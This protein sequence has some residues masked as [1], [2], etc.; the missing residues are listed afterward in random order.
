MTSIPVSRELQ[1]WFA[2]EG[3]RGPQLTQDSSISTA[4]G[5]G[6]AEQEN[7]SAG[8]ENSRACPPGGRFSFDKDGQEPL[9]G[10]YEATP[11][12][13][14]AQ[15]AIIER[16]QI[17]RRSYDMEAPT[18]R[19]DRNLATRILV[20]AAA[21]EKE[22]YKH[23]ARYQHRG[24]LG[25]L[26]IALLVALMNF[27]RKYGRIFPDYDTL[28]AMLRK[29]PET[30]VAAMKRLILHGFVTKH[31][32]S[33][34]I[35]TPQGDRR[36]Q[37]SNAYE[38]HM[39]NAGLSTV[40]IVADKASGSENPGVSDL[41]DSRKQRASLPDPEKDRWWLAEPWRMADGIVY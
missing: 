9:P 18:C 8:L 30:I 7:A 29:N 15:F 41:Q 4:G 17:H 1:A 16:G 31:R 25:D 20:K 12:E 6:L 35:G 32:R 28:A 19:I 33:K 5:G 13:M 37:D 36:V 40:P 22:S 26:G 2:R 3:R 38:V 14:A 27:S 11:M 23:R 21:M 34:M 39:P 10:V 24:V